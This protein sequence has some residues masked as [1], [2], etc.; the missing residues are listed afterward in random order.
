MVLL[1][2]LAGWLADDAWAIA[3]VLVGVFCFLFLTAVWAAP[4]Q[5]GGILGSLIIA[6]VGAGVLVLL[7]LVFAHEAAELDTDPTPVTAATATTS[8]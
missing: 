1:A 8:P 3:T 2:A 5:L 7:L 4:A 6:I